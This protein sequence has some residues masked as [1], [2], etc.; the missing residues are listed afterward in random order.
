MPTLLVVVAHPDD[1]TFGCGSVLLHAAERGRTVV[2]CLTRGEEGENAG[3]LALGAGGLGEARE[4]ELRAAA[5]LLRVDQVEVLDYRDSGMSGDLPPGSLCAAP[6]AELVD[7]VADAI[8]RHQP[9][10]VVALDGSDGHRDHQRVRE[11][12]V[13]ALPSDLPLYVSSLPRSLFHEW[14][15]VRGALGDTD[16]DLPEI[17]TPDEQLTTVLDTS[18]HYATRQLAIAEHRSQASPY[19]GLPA[20]LHRRFLASDYLVRINPPWSGGDRESDLVGLDSAA[21]RSEPR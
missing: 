6:L 3:G 1:E 5:A 20:D 11:A 16:A 10:V 13:A 4:A 19:E 15:R 8:S 9:S 21:G 18:R 14:L 7:V 17:G 12:V 2:V